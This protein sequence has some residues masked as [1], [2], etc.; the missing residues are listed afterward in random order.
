MTCSKNVVFTLLASEI[1][2]ET[3]K[4]SNR[5]KTLTPSCQKSAANWVICAGFKARNCNGLSILSRILVNYFLQLLAY[6]CEEGLL[7]H[8]QYI[9]GLNACLCKYF[10]LK[11]HALGV[12][13]ASHSP[14]QAA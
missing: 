11:I 14:S 10:D 6:H 2:R 12:L 5:M 13:T 3:S 7:H 4:L 9:I 1:A 8:L